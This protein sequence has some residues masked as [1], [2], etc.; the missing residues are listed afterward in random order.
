MA[1]GFCTC[2]RDF[3][4]AERFWPPENATYHYLCERPTLHAAGIV[5]ESD[6]A[7]A[8]VPSGT[9]WPVK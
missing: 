8:I 6:P 4:D 9:G 3:P 7:P 1:P 5:P 2:K